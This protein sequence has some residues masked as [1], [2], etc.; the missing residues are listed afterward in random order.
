MFDDTIGEE[1]LFTNKKVKEVYDREGRYEI[2]GLSI[3]DSEL[4]EKGPF[5]SASGCIYI[6]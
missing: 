1:R 2:P 4:I 5:I 3:E 6:G